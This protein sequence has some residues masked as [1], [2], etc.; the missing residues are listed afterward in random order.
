MAS[1][2]CLTMTRRSCGGSGLSTPN[3]LQRN[4]DEVVGCKWDFLETFK[5][6]TVMSLPQNPEI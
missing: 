3:G 2:L 4:C 6:I 1:A 5:N